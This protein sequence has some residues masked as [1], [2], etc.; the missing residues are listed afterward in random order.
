MSIA[1]VGNPNSG[2]TTLF[3]ALTGGKGHIGNWPGVT[4][5]KKE[6]PVVVDGV[7]HVMTDLP[8]IYSLDPDTAEQVVARDYL[9][10]DEVDLIINVIDSGN[11][12][13]S[14]I[15]TL[16]L[17]KLG[18]PVILALNMT[19][20]LE[21]KGAS[22]DTVRLSILLGTPAVSVSAAKK[23]NL[24][25]LFNQINSTMKS[26][27]MHT[28]CHGCAGCK[29]CGI[30]MGETDIESIVKQVYIKSEK[31]SQDLTERIDRIVL[32]KWL[33]LP[34]FILVMLTVFYLTFEAAGWLSGLISDFLDGVVSPG[35]LSLMQSIHAPDALTQ[36][37]SQ[38]VVSGVGSVLAFLPQ[39][40]ALFFLTSLLEDSGYMS[41]AAF[42][43]DKALSRIGLG[44][45][46]VMPLIMG[47]GCSV[48]AVMACRA[49]PSEK[50]RRLAIMLLPFCSCSAR[51]P[52]YALLA[53]AFFAKNQGLVILSL[54]LLG[55]LVAI[56]AG[57][58]LN[59][60]L[61]RGFDSAFVMEIPPYRLPSMKN[62]LLHAWERVKGFLTK[63][64]T[65][66]LGASVIIWGLQYFSPTFQQAVDPSHSLLSAI[67]RVLAPVFAPI[68][69]GDWRAAVSFLTGIFAKEA[70]VSTLGVLAG[71]ADGITA[72]LQTIFTPLQAYVFMV[73]SLLYIPCASTIV[74]IRREMNSLKYTVATVALG[75]GVAYAVCALIFNVGRL[76]GA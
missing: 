61:F 24:E 12:E 49:L 62:L 15:L 25:Q 29:S 58:I 36:L 73:F 63:A 37:L 55:I 52:V 38:G 3:N 27:S 72:T 56:V 28:S 76:I 17:L 35:L 60:T 43:A 7:K 9:V 48:P 40:A 47:F 57:V 21:S 1:L 53:G 64:G 46:A 67:G 10:R 22:I 42:I 19:D 65:V 8:G 6:G 50:E 75:L 41:R 33:A 69:L 20:E 5:D 13:R 23:K 70:I 2:K 11:L 44:G 30:G 74:T 71:G 34:V 68:G 39:I 51:L 26:G 16:Q 18:K 4:V 45:S 54:Y 59:K 14:L 32:N 31:K 66:L